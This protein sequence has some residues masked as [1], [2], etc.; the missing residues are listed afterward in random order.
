MNIHDLSEYELYKLKSIDPTLSSDWY[1]VIHHIIPKL[2][3][4][5]KHSVYRNILKPRGIQ[6]GLDGKLVYKRPDTL[7]TTLKNIQTKNND[8]NE[9]SLHMINLINSDTKDYDII[10][11]ADEIEAI[12]GRIDNLDI[13]DSLYDQ[14]NRQKIR[15][16]FLY[17]L[18]LW[19]D[20]INIKTVAGIRRLD[21]STIKAY[22][23]E[24]FIKHQIQG[25]DFRS[26]DSS[27]L[28]FQNLGHLPPFIK[29]E[30]EIRK[31]FIVEGRN[32]WFLVGSANKADNNPYS[33]RRF[34]HE[35]YSGDDDNKYIYLTHVVLKKD[36]MQSK[37]Y[38]SHAA[39]CITRLYTLDTGISE[40]ILKFIHEIQQ[41]YQSYLKPLL[42]KPLKQDGS[43]PDILVRKRMNKYE[44]QLSVLVLQKLPEIIQ[45]TKNDSNDQDY[46]FYHLDKLMKQIS[47]NV[48][49]F[50][51]QPLSMYSDSS[52]IMAVKI[53]AIRKLIQKSRVL[54][55]APEEVV[56]EHSEI[57]SKSLIMVR[58][59]LNETELYLR[60][61]EVLKDDVEQ[62]KYIKQT[63][64]FWQKRKLSKIPEY[65]S[66]EIAQI[67]LAIQDELFMS[68][69]RLAKTQNKSM[70]YLE[71][72]CGEVINEKYRHYAIA[73]GK[74]GISRLPRI[75]R[76]SEDKS[77]FDLE[78]LQKMVD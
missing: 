6:V 46:I 72:E 41:S 49:D 36:D 13:F 38:L 58:E 21:A 23:K 3:K 19:I 74:L 10:E 7:K 63:G 61:L 62:Y 51:L 70:V 53:I 15:I 64:S 73:D 71:F 55:C 56:G 9:I 65:S 26:W 47:D 16:A 30:G 37:Q 29:Q 42:K 76:L 75:L 22:F 44:T 60:E 11:L 33:F 34:L 39:Y 43:H 66:R 67:R 25:R 68:I 31:F 17:D 24:V 48:E 59:K 50:R 20:T 77:K 78:S 18:A 12:L 14:K 54:F 28:S 32:H 57:M 69:V 5:S 27:D 40:N 35:D 1:E 45:I 52:E 8:L 4:E 2:N